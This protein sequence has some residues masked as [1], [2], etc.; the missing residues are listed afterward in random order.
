MST[1][2]D[3]VKWSDDKPSETGNYLT[4]WSDGALETFTLWEEHIESEQVTAGNALLLF[5]AEN[6]DPPEGYKEK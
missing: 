6:V 5:W 3:W 1:S 4:Y 2:V